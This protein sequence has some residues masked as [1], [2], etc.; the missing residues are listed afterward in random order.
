SIAEK[1]FA[2]GSP[3]TLVPERVLERLLN[4]GIFAGCVPKGK[5]RGAITLGTATSNRLGQMKQDCDTNTSLSSLF[6]G[7][8]FALRVLAGAAPNTP[9]LSLNPADEATYQKYVAECKAQQLANP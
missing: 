8:D 9:F 7:M 2:V 4:Q 5:N 6:P 3:T 1:R